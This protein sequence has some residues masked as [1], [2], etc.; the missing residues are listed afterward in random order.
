MHIYSI[1]SYIQYNYIC[2]DIHIYR[3]IGKYTCSIYVQLCVRVCIELLCV[4]VYCICITIICLLEEYRG[5][6][7]YIQYGH[8]GRGRKRSKIVGDGTITGIDEQPARG[9]GSARVIDLANLPLRTAR[10]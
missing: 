3:Y 8:I 10:C 4:S 6:Y 7:T 1:Y 9:I 5:T 2:I